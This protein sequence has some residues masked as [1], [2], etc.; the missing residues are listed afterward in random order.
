MIVDYA[1]N[2]KKVKLVPIEKEDFIPYLDS[3]YKETITVC[4]NQDFEGFFVAKF[5]KL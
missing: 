5:I 3:K 4:P 2:T 1:L